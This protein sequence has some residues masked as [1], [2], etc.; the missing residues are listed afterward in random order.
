MAAEQATEPGRPKIVAAA[1]AAWDAAKGK[2]YTWSG[3]TTDG[4]DCSGFVCY[5]LQQSYPSSQFGF[6]TAASL[7]ADARF[8]DV[9]GSPQYGDLICFKKGPSTPHDHVGIVY[10][11]SNWLG[12]QS[13][14]GVALVLFSNSYWSAKTKF[15][16]RLIIS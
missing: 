6:M 4:F 13:S 10:D 2:A 8:S 7:F 1:K 3:H 5:V 11:Q 14:T 15:F 16:R 12:S 9:T